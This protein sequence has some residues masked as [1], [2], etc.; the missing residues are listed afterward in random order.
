MLNDFQLQKLGYHYDANG[1]LRD[2]CNWP[3]GHKLFIHPSQALT[4]EDVKEF[5][6]IAQEKIKN[7]I[8]E[9]EIDLSFKNIEKENR[10]SKYYIIGAIVGGVALVISAILNLSYDYYVRGGG[11]I[12]R[13]E[14]VCH[15]SDKDNAKVASILQ[16]QEVLLKWNQTEQGIVTDTNHR[17]LDL[18]SYC[19]RKVK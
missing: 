10:R 6:R 9:K 2:F 18:W 13:Q 15:F 17:V 19:K 11:L 14:K 8:R 1:I 16:N 7:D 12:K 5:R 3:E 4:I